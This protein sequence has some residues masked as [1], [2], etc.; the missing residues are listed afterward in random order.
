MY[1]SPAA[2][3]AVLDPAGLGVS[4]HTDQE[5]QD[6]FDTFFEDVFVEVEDKYG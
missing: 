4:Q 3:A 1:Q 5:L 2:T 6:H